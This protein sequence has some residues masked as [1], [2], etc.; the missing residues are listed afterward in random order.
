M[1]LDYVVAEGVGCGE[2]GE[3]ISDR[4]KIYGGASISM[5]RELAS[6]NHH[7]LAILSTRRLTLSSTPN[8][9][10]ALV[11]VPGAYKCFKHATSTLAARLRSG[12]MPV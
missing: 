12:R 4:V 9:L 11:S 1:K 2:V 6:E 7:P 10:Q 8:F 3:C 5:Q